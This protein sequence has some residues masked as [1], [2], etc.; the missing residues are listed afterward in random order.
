M[1]RRQPQPSSKGGA[2]AA[3]QPFSQALVSEAEGLLD[4][5]KTDPA[6]I[7]PLRLSLRHPCLAVTVRPGIDLAPRC[8]SLWFARVAQDDSHREEA[9]QLIDLGRMWGSPAKPAGGRLSSRLLNEALQL[10]QRLHWG[11]IFA[12]FASVVLWAGIICGVR[13]LLAE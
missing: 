11:R 13:W 7:G 3:G 8:T 5:V 10:L 4:A 1:F 2:T 6:K 9:M 12:I